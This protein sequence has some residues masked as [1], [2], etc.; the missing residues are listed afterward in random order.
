MRRSL[1]TAFALAT[2]ILA[3]TASAKIQGT[4]N[5]RKYSD[6]APNARATVGSVTI[7]ARALIDA[8]GVTTI[9]VA[10]T[11]GK[12]DKVQLKFG[13]TRIY[14]NLDTNHFIAPTRTDLQPGAT[15]TITA[16]VFAEWSKRKEILTVTTTVRRLPDITALRIDAPAVV[17]S[18]AHVTLVAVVHEKNGDT[19]ARTDVSLLLDGQQVDLATNLWVDAGG[20]VSILYTTPALSPGTH[21]LRITASNVDPDD[22][23][24]TNNSA[25][26]QIR[27][28]GDDEDEWSATASQITQY[29][30]STST[31]SDRPQHPES[32][33]STRISDSLAFNATIQRAFNVFGARMRVTERTNGELIQDVNIELIE[34]AGPYSP[35]KM[36]DGKYTIF[37]VCPDNG[38]T[39]INVTRGAGEVMYISRGWFGKYNRDTGET[40]YEQYVI[41]DHNTYGNPKRYRD[42]VQVDVTLSD[43]TNTFTA[44]PYMILQQ[45]DDVTNE[46]SS[47]T[48]INDGTGATMCS[49]SRVRTIVERGTDESQ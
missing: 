32:T 39:I 49:Q 46:Q 16:H 4:S 26:A 36:Y 27:V 48:P 17:Q 2:L 21:Q 8:Q 30:S 43:G 6:R 38:K 47:C 29:S 42:T 23:D 33:E 40:V 31:R 1:L 13:K 44:D 14:N 3:T 19:G 22:W 45:V 28:H 34:S 37:T 25:T 12:L 10:S 35:C 9:E 5:A 41:E 7:E 15:I 11:G 20:V 24:G 18:G